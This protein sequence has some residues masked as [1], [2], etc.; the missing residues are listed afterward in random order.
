MTNMFHILNVS[1][2]PDYPETHPVA[3]ASL[4]LRDLPASDSQ[5]LGLKVCATTA[6]H[7][8]IFLK[9]CFRAHV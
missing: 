3:E 7:Q 1:S 8:D 9:G 6:P 5:V 2:R 4:K